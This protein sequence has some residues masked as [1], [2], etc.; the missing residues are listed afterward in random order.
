MPRDRYARQS[1]GATQ[2]LVKESRVLL[3][4]AGGIGCELLKNLVLTGF[5]EIHVID[6]DTIDLSNLNRQF[7]FRH[8]HIKKPK[9]LVAKDVAQKFNPNVKLFAY[10][11]NIKDRQFN[12]EWF[13][14]FNIVFNAL[15]NMDARRHVNKMCLA[16]DVPLVESGTTGFRGQ[17]QV[18]KK[19]ETACYDC[20]P[21]TTPISYPVCTIRSTP[22]QPIHCIVWAKSYLLPELFGVS[23]DEAAELDSSEDT[24]NAEEIKKLKEEA[25]AL[26]KIRASMGSNDFA[27]QVFD[28]VFKEDIERLA[29]MEDMW[30]DKK[31]PEPL[32]Y[33]ELEQQATMVDSGVARNGQGTWSVVENFVVFKD[34]LDRLVKRLSQEQAAA[35]KSGELQPS[36]SFDKDDDDTMDF[37]TA[38]GN[39]R[40]IIFGIEPKS[41]F[42]I[43]QM[44][45]NIIPAIAT[46]NAMIAGL[47]V[48]QAFKVF[49]GDYARTRWLWLGIGSLRTDQLDLPNPECPV[50]S[51]A[52]ARVQV[53][54]ERATLADLVQDILRTRLGYGEEVTVMTEA[55]VVYDPDLEDNLEKKLSDLNIGDASFLLIKDEDD[56]PRVD[57][58]IAIEAKK[59]ADETKVV[60]LEKEGEKLEIPRKPKKQSAPDGGHAEDDDANGI[61]VTNGTS[62]STTL[63]SGKRKR[64]LDDEGDE[65]ATPAKKLQVPSS[66]VVKNLDMQA[67]VI[68]DD[69]GALVIADDE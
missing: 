22:S 41:K 29:K 5:G 54:V 30:K 50:C 67:I 39:L 17:V 43:K 65:S 12:L 25:Q 42:D 38:A 14:G 9:A 8:E 40:A 21:K 52:M 35:S 20:T 36:I 32:S 59:A 37:V 3:V 66:E 16:V 60:L 33:D 1:L 57:L 24:D 47:C 7:L 6:L 62:S 64:P 4:G 48:L 18:I 13:S 28:K 58:Q 10:H 44:A 68:D 19:G 55:G 15:D 63:P 31:P 61:I 49:K 53:D 45:G 27:K 11:A 26:K 23:E 51:V 56:D 2:R 34:S 69:D 46:T